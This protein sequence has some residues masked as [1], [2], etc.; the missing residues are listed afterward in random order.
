MMRMQSGLDPN[1]SAQV[2]AAV[3]EEDKKDAKLASDE[4][5]VPSTEKSSE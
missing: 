5:T 1:T 4:S 3:G 2:D